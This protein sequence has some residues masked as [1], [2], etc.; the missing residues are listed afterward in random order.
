MNQPHGISQQIDISSQ[1]RRD[2]KTD[3]EFRGVLSDK[4]TYEY[5]VKLAQYPFIA[6]PPPLT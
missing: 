2:G 4:M 1:G 6:R 5:G 3:S